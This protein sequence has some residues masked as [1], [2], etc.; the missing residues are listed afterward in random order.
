MI[1]LLIVDDHALIRRGLKLIF[2]ETPDIRVRDEARDSTEALH[3][4]AHRSFD[5]L[6]LDISLPGRSGLDLL[7]QV[8]DQYPDLPILVLSIHPENQYALRVIKAGASGY[9]T[10]DSPPEELIDAIRKI[11][12]GKKHLTDK[13]V[14]SIVTQINHT[15]EEPLYT[16]LSDREYQILI[17]LANGQSISE[18]AQDL[19]LSIK[20]IS[21]YRTRI[22]Q[23]LQLKNTAEIICY[24]LRQG[25]V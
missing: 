5:A 11:V 12:C 15:S 2:E 20:T 9:L 21:T 10:K 8:H 25:L 6:I 22:L 7:K 13:T 18:I 19:A 1:N 24:A 4:L 14:E 16:T 17:K 3:L 23:K